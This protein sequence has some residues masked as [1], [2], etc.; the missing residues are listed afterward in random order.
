MAGD[1]K[2]LKETSNYIVSAGKKRLEKSSLTLILQGMLAGIFIGFGAIAY[3]KLASLAADP[4]LGAF[5]GS[6]I[7]PVGI[8]AILM[9]G[10]ELFTS[11]TMMVMGVYNRE[12]R[13]RKVL[14]VLAIV[15]LA[16]L[17]GMAVISALSSFSGIFTQAMTDKI[18]HTAEA[19]TSMS[20]ANLIVS[21]I[22]CNMIVCT[23]VWA[24]YAMKK[25]GVKILVLWMVI[26]VFALSGTEHV[27]ANAYYMFTAYLLGAD[28]SFAGIGY[29][30][31]YVTI[32]NFI[33][34]AVVITGLNKLIITK[35]RITV[36]AT[37]T[38]TQRERNA[39]YAKAYGGVNENVITYKEDKKK[40]KK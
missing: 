7:F 25:A 21:A 36:N 13:M 2:T 30:L 29:N 23:G 5:L 12:Y 24:A 1:I 31:M 10:S 27:V 19:K 40:T 14:K 15:L 9:L 16:N 37:K 18:I 39:I 38:Y 22:L 32:G 8:V 4:G 33:G 11:N 20:V 34:G 28:I 26:T 17:L 3:F 6:A 35:R